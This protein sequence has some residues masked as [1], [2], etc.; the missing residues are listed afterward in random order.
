MT[1]EVIL[2]VGL[3]PKHQCSYLGHEQEQL[4]VLMDHNLLNASGYE[5]LL[6]AG[7]RRSGNDI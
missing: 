2:K 1:E 3:T 6:T 5:R 4:L 7:F